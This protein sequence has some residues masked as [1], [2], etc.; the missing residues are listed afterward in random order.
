MPK[1]TLTG[2]IRYEYATPMQD[3]HG[4]IA[5]VDIFNSTASQA[6]YII[7]SKAQQK[8]S[9]VPL[10]GIQG[11]P[12]VAIERT[13]SPFIPD[14]KDWSPRVSVAYRATDS[15]VV[16][17]GYGIY[18]DF[19]QSNIQNQQL[20]M[21]AY[22]FGIPDSAAVNNLSSATPR[23]QNILGGTVFPPFAPSVTVPA[24]LSFA[25]ARKQDRPYLQAWDLGVEK[26]LGGTLLL[27]AAYVGSKGTR[28]PISAEFNDSPTAGPGTPVRPLPQFG[29]MYAIPNVGVSNYAALQLKAEERAVHGLT[30]LAAYTYSRSIDE[31]SASNGSQQPGESPQNAYDLPGSRGVSDFDLPQNFVLSSVYD[32]P[33]GTGKRFLGGSGWLQSKVLGGWQTTG[34]L[35]LRSGFPFTLSI[36]GTTPISGP[37][38]RPRDLRPLVLCCRPDFSEVLTNGSIH[39]IWSSSRIP[40]ERLAATQCARV[41]IRTSTSGCLRTRSLRKN[42][43]CSSEPRPSI[44]S[45]TQ[46]GEFRFQPLV[47]HSL[48]RC[49]LPV[50]P[51]I[52][53]LL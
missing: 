8:Y 6:Y 38:I 26:D 45:T 1:L 18:Y 15:L 7:D 2:G 40:S 17:T 12:N 16:R 35:S 34:I 25:I 49:L 13:P 47:P 5:G 31:S 30:F 22:P 14:H 32:L 19:N 20:I 41:V 27:S 42:W 43:S 53:S 21:G 51:G 23:P 52:F 36:S 50:I 37:P 4:R 3:E 24:N 29:A 39:P 46:I 11:G 48:A 9:L 28:L 44:S 10:N 33:I